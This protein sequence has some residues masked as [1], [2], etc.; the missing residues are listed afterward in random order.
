M[1]SSPPRYDM[2]LPIHKALRALMSDTL[3]AVGRADCDD[4]GEVAAALAQVRE[5]LHI[6][7]QHLE[8]ENRFVHAAL[9]R[10]R[11]GS[12]LRI[13][14]EHIEHLREI[15]RLRRL[16]AEVGDAT[17]IE[18]YVVAGRL[19]GELAHFVA[20]N[21]IHMEIEEREHNVA[22][23]SAYTDAEL[24]AIEGE[25]VASIPPAE[26]AVL[27]RW[28]LA[29]NQHGFRVAMLG[30]L[31]AHAPAEVFEGMLGVARACLGERDW[32]KLSTALELPQAA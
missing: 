12:S 22:L 24:Q 28:M 18:R 14:D 30:G 8:H 31:R 6:C 4:A 20:E 32:H 29:H 21:L 10:R 11:P 16:A 5:L 15:D 25:L 2:Y 19:Y 13:A 27:A 3:D 23:W 1:P 26:M 17:G 9:E 7:E